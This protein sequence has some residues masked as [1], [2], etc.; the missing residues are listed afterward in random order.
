MDNRF[1]D[2]LGGI[3]TLGLKGS[4][5]E[6]I[7]NMALTRGIYIWNVKR[8][9]DQLRLKVRKSAFPALKNIAAEQGYDLE[10]LNQEGL[11]FYRPVLKRRLGFLAGALIFILSMYLMSSFIWFIEV[12]G[13]SQVPAEQIIKAAARH[14]LYPG[15][16]KWNISRNGI[17]EA[18]LQDLSHLTYI[19]CNIKGVRARIK[20]VEKILPEN[21]SGPCHI[22]ACKGG[23]IEEVLVLAGQATVKAGDVVGKGD[24]L[25]SGLVYPPVPYGS[26]GQPV[27]QQPPEYV[28][29]RGQVMARTWYEGYGECYLR[30]EKRT[31]TGREVSRMY[32]ETP[33]NKF[34]LK[35]RTGNRFAHYQQVNKSKTWSTALGN[36]GIYKTTWKEESVDLKEYSAEE[37]AEIAR[38]KALKSLKR[39]MLQP[40]RIT[41]SYMSVLSSP[42]EPM[43]RVKVATEVLEDISATQAINT[44]DIN[45]NL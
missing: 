12:S 17:E 20:V 34:V 15:A 9:D 22:V 28:R 27:R 21:A 14:G 30:I 31:L 41:D 8:N 43:V 5:Q 42:S 29:A 7:I 6:K 10:I 35:G 38:E 18:I 11:P 2:Y 3:I 16:A 24:I 19:E 4:H 23:V 25:I 33:W 36:W 26:E 1:L 44:G 45:N 13:N 39:N 32:L 37:A 40:F